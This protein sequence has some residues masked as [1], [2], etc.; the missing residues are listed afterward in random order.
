M[1]INICI[2]LIVTLIKICFKLICF[3]AIV[4]VSRDVT[5][6][7]QEEHPAVKNMPAVVFLETW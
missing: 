1:T 4:W 5:G 3:Y 7:T 2:I 6:S